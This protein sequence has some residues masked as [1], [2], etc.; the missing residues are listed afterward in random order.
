MGEAT[1]ATESEFWNVI[2]VE[3][4]PRLYD[5]IEFAAG[6]SDGSCGTCVRMTPGGG[7]A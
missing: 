1:K 3:I 5:F 6:A 4:H 7:L 2:N